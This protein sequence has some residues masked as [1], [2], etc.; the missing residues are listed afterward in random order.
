MP[1]APRPRSEGPGA[2]PRPARLL[3]A[4]QTGNRGGSTC[5]LRAASNGA[6]VVPSYEFWLPRVSQRPLRTHRGARVGDGILARDAAP[7]QRSRRGSRVPHAPRARRFD[8]A[9]Q[10]WRRTGG[11]RSTGPRRDRGDGLTD[12]RRGRLSV[13]RVPPIPDA[14]RGRGPK[15][16]HGVVRGRDVK[17]SRDRSPP[18]RRAD[19][20]RADADRPAPAD[21]PVPD[22]GRGTARAARTPR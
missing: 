13:D 10:T 16:V 21:V 19:A 5:D 6:Q 17:G 1:A 7:R 3:Q 4:A 18:L 9:A 8:V 2:S 12:L 11:V 22:P 20:R 14:P 15:P